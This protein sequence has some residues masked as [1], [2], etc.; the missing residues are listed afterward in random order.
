MA[1]SME[2]VVKSEIIAQTEPNYENSISSLKG[3]QSHELPATCL[4]PDDALA[5]GV[6]EKHKNDKILSSTHSV[7]EPKSNEVC[8]DLD[9]K[10]DNSNNDSFALSTALPPWEYLLD[11]C[12]KLRSNDEEEKLES[13]S[14]IYLNRLAYLLNSI[15]NVL[16]RLKTLV[17]ETCTINRTNGTQCKREC[18]YLTNNVEDKGIFLSKTM[19][20]LLGHEESRNSKL[21]V[22]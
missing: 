22:Y 16:E 1:V 8:V 9:E 19:S 12:T 15:D 5:V 3:Y 4:P 14:G 21:V 6:L 7:L 17:N 2:A 18:N 10:I 13:Y 11:H 20:M